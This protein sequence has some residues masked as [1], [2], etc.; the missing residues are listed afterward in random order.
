MTTLS[1]VTIL[2]CSR[3]VYGYMKIHHGR[4]ICKYAPNLTISGPISY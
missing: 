2:P 3:P 1:T 4:E